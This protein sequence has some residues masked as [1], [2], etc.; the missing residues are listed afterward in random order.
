MIKQENNAVVPHLIAK[1]QEVITKY[2][3]E[4]MQRYPNDLLVH[5]R[6]TL[7]QAAVPGAK[8]AWMVGHCHTHLVHLGIH[9]K[10]NLNVTYLTNLADE[11]RFFV[12]DIGQGGRFKMSEVERG[13]F[14]ALSRTHVPYE[15]RGDVSNFW[16]YRQKERVGH[17]TLQNTGTLHEP[18]VSVT[19]TPMFG[20]SGLDSAALELWAR[21]A[22]VEMARTLFVRSDVTWAKPIQFQRAA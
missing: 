8:F 5:D 1:M 2:G 12:L 18:K 19:I 16:L 15:R 7:E 14:S 22:T 17:V 11:D 3:L 9:P 10:E 21:N 4:L 13:A 20:I 6:A